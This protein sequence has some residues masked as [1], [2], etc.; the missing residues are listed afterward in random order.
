[1][2]P[3]MSLRRIEGQS[4]EGVS[5]V[6]NE[7]KKGEHFFLDRLQQYPPLK[8]VDIVGRLDRRIGEET[9]QFTGSGIERFHAGCDR[10]RP[11]VSCGYAEVLTRELPQRLLR[12]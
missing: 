10:A 2:K 1:M 12:V 8:R 3:R 6:S 4:Y 5:H 7:G 9:G 11:S